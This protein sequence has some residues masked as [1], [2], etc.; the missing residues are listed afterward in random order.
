M[1]R[2]SRSDRS[3]RAHIAKFAKFVCE[4]AKLNGE[5]CPPNLLYL[6]ICEIRDRHLSETGGEDALNVLNKADKRQVNCYVFSINCLS[7]DFWE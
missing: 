2:S 6:L 1:R 7:I 5:R 3:T 4:V